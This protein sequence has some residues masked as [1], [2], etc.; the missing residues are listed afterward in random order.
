V[1][2]KKKILI[3]DDEE[4]FTR[5]VKLNLESTG[6]FEVRIENK[7]ELGFDA[8]KTF[9]PDLILL[10]IVMPDMEGSEVATKI[11]QDES[12][13]NTP[14][15]FLTCLVRKEEEGGTCSIK[16]GYPFIAKPVNLKELINC[17]DKIIGK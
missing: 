7:G 13:K 15:V 12:V 11:K 3:I 8:A 4:S 9:H 16:G 6:R 10:D 5:L 14:I 17:I 2:R 1:E